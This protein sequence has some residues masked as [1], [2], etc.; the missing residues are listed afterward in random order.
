[1]EPEANKRVARGTRQKKK[2]G[3]AAEKERQVTRNDDRV[4]PQAMRKSKVE[5][6][7]EKW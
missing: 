3:R 1:M 5:R 2:R 4:R 7:R 6:D